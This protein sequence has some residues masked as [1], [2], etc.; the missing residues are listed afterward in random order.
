MEQAEL[1]LAELREIKR[2]QAETAAALQAVSLECVAI[3]KMAEAAQRERL[4]RGQPIGVGWMENH[5]GDC[6]RV[7]SERG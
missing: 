4:A 7:G 2:L 1:L 3:K 6:E 5:G